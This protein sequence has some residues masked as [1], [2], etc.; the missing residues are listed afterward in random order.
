MRYRNQQTDGTVYNFETEYRPKLFKRIRSFRWMDP[1]HEVIDTGVRMINSEIEIL[2]RQRESH[3][4][5]DFSYFERYAVPESSLSPRLHRLYAQELF[6]AG[7][8]EDFARAYT[9]FEHTLHEETRSPDEIRQSQCVVTRCCHLR[10]DSTGL[11]KAA[12][13]N[14]VGKPSAEVCCEL[15]DFFYGEGDFEEAATWYYTAA[16]GAESELDVHSAGD[17]PL[18]CL[19]KCFDTLGDAGE[20]ERYRRLAD[21]WNPQNPF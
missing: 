21:E 14:M 17:L 19:S 15:G 2:H 9:Y 20:A 7:T 1:V 13:K 3:A 6:L 18:R 12:L 16:F 5:R 8:E 11:F 4:G 10:R